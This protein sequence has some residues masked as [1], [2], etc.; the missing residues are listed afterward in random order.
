MCH[1]GAIVMR[2]CS[3]TPSIEDE[4]GSAMRFEDYKKA[5]IAVKLQFWKDFPH[6]SHL[7]E[8]WPNQDLWDLHIRDVCNEALLEI[9]FLRKI[10]GAVSRGPSFEDFKKKARGA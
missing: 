9:A 8:D 10:S 5:D 3:P 1:V 6:G 2:S 4:W 7:P